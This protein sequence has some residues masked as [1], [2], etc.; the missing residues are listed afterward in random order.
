MYWETFKS[1]EKDGFDFKVSYTNEI[2]HSVDSFDDS[3]DDI[4]EIVREIE[5]GTYYWLL[6][7]LELSVDGVVLG[8]SYVGEVLVE[9]LSQIEEYTPCLEDEA[10]DEAVGWLNRNKTLLEQLA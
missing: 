10:I 8:T 3:V 1:Y 9:E 2:I 4:D 6:L 5:N 7:R